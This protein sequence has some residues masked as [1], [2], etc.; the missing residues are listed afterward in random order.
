MN[1]LN[2]FKLKIKDTWHQIKW[3]V[4]NVYN[5][6]KDSI[7]HAFS[8]LWKRISLYDKRNEKRKQRRQIIY[9]YAIKFSDEP[10]FD[11]EHL[12]YDNIRSHIN[13]ALVKLEKSDPQREELLKDRKSVV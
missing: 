9:N 1:V 2:R 4:R 6:V 13:D 7:K 10:F 5:Q 3:N 11:G 8:K 12:R